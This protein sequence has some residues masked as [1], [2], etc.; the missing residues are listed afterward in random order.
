MLFR[1]QV[2]LVSHDGV[3]PLPLMSKIEVASAILDRLERLL[4]SK[5]T[6]ATR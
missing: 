4:V 5:I 2:T 6:V 1:S 3:E